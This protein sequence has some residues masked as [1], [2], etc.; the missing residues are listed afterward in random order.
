MTGT[1]GDYIYTYSNVLQECVGHPATHSYTCPVSI[2]I[3]GC[4]DHI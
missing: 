1:Y 3:S 2:T 4:P